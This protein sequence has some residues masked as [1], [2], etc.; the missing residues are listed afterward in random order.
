MV[1]R[2]PRPPHRGPFYFGTPGFTMRCIPVRLVRVLLLA[3]SLLI[4]AGCSS[5]SPRFATTGSEHR[6][7]EKNGNEGG[8]F[9]FAAKI[10]AEEAREDDRK[11]DIGRTKERLRARTQPVG[12]YA[13]ITPAGLNRD[14]VL[15]DV[16][17][18]LGVPYAHGGMSKDG[19][20]CSG[21]TTYV[22]QNAAH[23]SLPRTVD[24][25]YQSGEE[26]IKDSLQFGDLVFFN[27]TGE[28]P[29]HVGIYIED[30]LFAHA[31]VSSGVTLS[32]LESTYYSRRYVGA[33]R[34][35]R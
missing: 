7:P 13:N 25:Q 31:S 1:G 34:V 22:Y 3:P 9:R 29:S 10:R 8:E 32:S 12:R 4:L 16:V 15:L 19:M 23:R 17:S 18:F 26:V 6:R 33:R 14:R 28:S 2:T 24:G 35:A 20:D 30:D 21:F 11:V 5:S 27:T